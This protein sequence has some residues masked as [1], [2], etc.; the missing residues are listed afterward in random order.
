MSTFDTY[1]TCVVVVIY[2]FC[3]AM[4]CEAFYVLTLRNS[5]SFQKRFFFVPSFGATII[6]V[7]TQMIPALPLSGT[8]YSAGINTCAIVY[9]Q[10][11]TLWVHVSFNLKTDLGLMTGRQLSPNQKVSTMTQ[12]TVLRMNTDV[13]KYR[14]L[15]SVLLSAFLISVQLLVKQSF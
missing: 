2:F 14:I 4:F 5:S 7:Y 1:N 15:K 11:K 9:I 6:D 12:K 3:I 8:K 10:S 13:N